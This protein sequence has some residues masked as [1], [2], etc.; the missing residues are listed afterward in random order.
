MSLNCS[1]TGSGWKS[2]D[3]SKIETFSWLLLLLP[4]WIS[5][6]RVTIA[7]HH[8]SFS[9]RIIPRRRQTELIRHFPEGL[10]DH[11]VAIQSC[12]LTLD[13]TF[14]HVIVVFQ[15][16]TIFCHEQ[17][18]KR[19]TASLRASVVVLIWQQVSPKL[20]ALPPWFVSNLSRTCQFRSRFE[21][22]RLNGLE[23]EIQ[24][25][26]QYCVDLHG[27][28]HMSKTG[29]I[30]V[31]LRIHPFTRVFFSHRGTVYSRHK[32][33]ILSPSSVSSVKRYC[34]HSTILKPASEHSLDNFWSSDNCSNLRLLSCTNGGQ[35]EFPSSP[36]DQVL[37]VSPSFLNL[38]I[39]LC[40]DLPLLRRHLADVQKLS[41]GE[42][43]RCFLRY[44][45]SESTGGTKYWETGF[46][47]CSMIIS[48]DQRPFLV[49]NRGHT[50]DFC[51][52][53]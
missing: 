28:K 35:Q 34:P 7:K 47:S 18:E 33:G 53:Y 29:P 17:D 14:D 8:Q 3:S 26:L 21:P 10:F 6:R 22:E 24:P 43:A 38:R 13:N 42:A 12:L 15:C 2:L 49:I 52:I 31:F 44:R 23:T 5:N 40:T 39:V 27:D 45:W 41:C 30:L 36:N 50:S 46:C 48:A 16:L 19:K 32:C 9:S 1:A 37:Q 4:E 20:Y 51:L 11:V 25:E